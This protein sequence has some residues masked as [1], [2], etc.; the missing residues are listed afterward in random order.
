MPKITVTVIGADDTLS[1]I[2]SNS[3]VDNKGYKYTY[4]KQLVSRLRLVKN[5]VKDLT[6][7]QQITIIGNTLIV[8][9]NLANFAAEEYAKLNQDEL[10]ESFME[11][12]D[13][14]EDL[15]K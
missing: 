3:I 7:E 11:I 12:V 1:N 4:L 9:R 15:F 5:N 10:F 13:D 14:I 2:I 8:E 6:E